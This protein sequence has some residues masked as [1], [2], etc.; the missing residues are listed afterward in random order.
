MAKTKPWQPEKPLT[1]FFTPTRMDKS[2]EIRKARIKNINLPVLQ[3][4][5]NG[6]E[7][8]PLRCLI[9]QRPGW[10][11][12]PCVV[13]GVDKQRF[14]IDFNHIRQLQ[15]GNNASGTSVDKSKYDP[16]S[17]F[18]DKVL[19]KHKELLYEFMAI[20]PL[21]QEYHSYVSQDSQKG[22]ITLT[23]FD[24]KYWPWVLQSE[25]NYNTFI[26]KYNIE[27]E[28]T[29]QWLIDH[30]SDINSPPI[31]NRVHEMPTSKY[32]PTGPNEDKENS[33]PG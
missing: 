19:I 3:M 25:S 9:T 23:N 12:F 29:Y 16:S 2:A 32:A 27:T 11:D 1:K 22:H 28:L 6:D 30:L 17:V 7:L 20:M 33:I 21:S 15:T 8:T 13:S 18:R 4:M 5:Y 24:T 31:F 14:D 26:R 10:T